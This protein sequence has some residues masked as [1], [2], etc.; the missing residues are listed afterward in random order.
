MTLAT[1]LGAGYAPYR[2]LG[3]NPPASFP[4]DL[5][6]WDDEQRL[7]TAAFYRGEVYLKQAKDGDYSKAIERIRPRG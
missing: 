3:L 7:I 6:E 1:L 5:R 2:S 4:N